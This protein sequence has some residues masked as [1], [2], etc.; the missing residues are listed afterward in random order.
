MQARVMTQEFQ[1]AKD[2]LGSERKAV[3]ALAG[4]DLKDDQG[5][6]K[7]W[8][9]VKADKEN[10]TKS[11]YIQPSSDA[12]RRDEINNLVAMYE[13]ERKRIRGF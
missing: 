4:G 12:K 11:W 10:F 8:A 7:S 1:R 6:L 9:E 13:A 3:F 2:I 5:N